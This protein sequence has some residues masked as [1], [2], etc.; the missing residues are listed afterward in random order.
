MPRIQSKAVLEATGRGRRA[1]LQD[2][3]EDPA[4]HRVPH[5]DRA[6]VHFQLRWLLRGSIVALLPLLLHG[7]LLTPRACAAGLQSTV[8]AP[9]NPSVSESLSPALDQVGHSVGQIQIDHWKVSKSWKEQLQSDANSISSDLSHQLP[10]LLQQAQSTPTDLGA[11]L[12]LMQNVN[13]LYDVLVRLTLAADLTEKKSDSALLNSALERL[14][15]AKKTATTSMIATAAQQH[16]QLTDLSARME[17]IQASGSVSAPHGKTIVVDN[18]VRREPVHH[19]HHK[20]TSP[21]TH[22]KSQAPPA[23]ATG[24]KPKAQ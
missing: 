2:M 11:Q 23:P 7:V 6:S 20:K 9:A 8:A 18:D 24:D 5:C 19:A 3:S 12:R 15:A 14:E 1:S 22:S 16:Q 10:G 4:T 21:S 13:A 17:A